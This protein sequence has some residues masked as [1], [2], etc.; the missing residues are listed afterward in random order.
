MDPDGGPSRKGLRIDEASRAASTSSRLPALDALRGLAMLLV[1]VAHAGVS[2]AATRVPRLLWAIRDS[3][4]SPEF[5]V[6]FW[7]SISVAMPLFFL[8]SGFLAAQLVASRGPVEFLKN[9]ARRI[10]G[11]F[12]AAAAVVL[13][14]SLAVWAMGWLISGRCK[15]RQLL[16]MRFLDPDITHYLAGPAH[17]WF[18]EYLILMLAA[19]GVYRLLRTPRPA[20]P[21]DATGR[22]LRSAVAP[23][24]LAIP[25]ALILWTGHLRLGL[26]AIFDLRNSFLPDPFRW[27]HH[28]WFFVVGVGLYRLR[29]QLDRFVAHSGWRLALALPAFWIR[30]HL[31][32]RDLLIPL[33]GWESV[34]LAASGAAFAW[35]VL[36]GLLGLAQWSCHRPRASLRYV[37]DSSYW[38]YLTHFPVTGLA[39]VALAGVPI[40]AWPKFFLVLGVTFG[41]G[42]GSYQA[43][44]RNTWLGHWLN[45]PAPSRRLRP[46]NPSVM[47]DRMNGLARH[48]RS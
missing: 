10:V 25:T 40:A 3:S 2:F 26:D 13:P 28:A 33:R 39:Q 22:L 9:R 5:D 12:F 8:M 17:L 37:A 6:L 7:G 38:I 29:D 36:F 44:V 31:L 32:R 42:L 11:P 24:V 27:A 48:P 4:R 47:G 30:V 21:D 23:F 1:I 16:R 15:W 34:A 20:A 35:L 18:L 46:R 19:Y 41:V 43:L 45:G 14:L